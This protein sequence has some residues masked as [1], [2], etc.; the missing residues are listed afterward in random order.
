M[1]ALGHAVQVFEP[2]QNWSLSNL[3]EE[4]HGQE[5]LQAFTQVYAEIALTTYPEDTSSTQWRDYLRQTDVVILHEWTTPQLAHVLLD[6][7]AKLGFALLFHDTHHRASSSPE[8]IRRFGIERFNG[9]LAFGNVLR[10]LYRSQFGLENVWT[11]HEAA[12]TSVFKPLTAAAPFDQDVVWIGNWGDEERSAEIRE[13]LLQPAKRSKNHSFT[14]Y[15]VRYP[16]EGLQAL[17]ESGIRY[18]GYL[19]NLSAPRIYANSRLTVHIPRR[20]YATTMVGIP[21]IRVFEALACGIPLVSAPWVDAEQL[22]R[23][24]DITFV[25]TS[26]QMKTRMDQL[27]DNP[28]LAKAQAARGLETILAHHTCDHRAS[29]LTAICHEVLR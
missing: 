6:V 5:S 15:G 20:Q 17:T 18:G 2:A 27:L 19:P 23:P 28:A 24:D 13:F 26:D 14:I 11:L 29:E 1:T 12:D 9:V 7:R 4:A 25:K 22:F 3:L 8:Q 10:D 21:T 16:A